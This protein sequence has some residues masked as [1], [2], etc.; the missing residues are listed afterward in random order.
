[1]RVQWKDVLREIVKR[2]LIHGRF[3]NTISLMEY[4][5]ARKIVKSQFEKN[6]DQNV[7]NHMNEEI[8]HAQVFKKMALKVSGGELK[9]YDEPYL[10]AGNEARA[11]LQC[12]DRS[13]ESALNGENSYA[14]YL[15]STLLIEER[16][17]EIYPFYSELMEPLGFSHFIKNILKEEELHLQDTLS[18][19][20]ENNVLTAAQLSALR[21][22]EGQAF[23]QLIEA[24]AR[25]MGMAP[26][27]SLESNFF[28]L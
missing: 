2:P 18:A 25:E 14:N 3:L 5:G 21:M 11:Y 17:N 15:L 1:M 7:L 28:S 4:I 8:R 26:T 20:Q 27:I 22:I 6:I 23:Q 12:V 19:L 13:V 10:I 24:I 9:T 16:A